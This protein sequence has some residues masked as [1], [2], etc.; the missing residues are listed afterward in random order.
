PWAL[1]EISM[2]I[3]SYLFF[4]V[5]LWLTAEVA[6]PQARKKIRFA[7]T[8]RTGLLLVALTGFS[9]GCGGGGSSAAAVVAPPPPP[10]RIVTPPGTSIITVTPS[11]K[12]AAGAPLQL[13]PIQLT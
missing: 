4:V 3:I 9:A 7:T 2:R 6:V 11:A 13:Q 10:A 8:V 12:N 1:P 5:L